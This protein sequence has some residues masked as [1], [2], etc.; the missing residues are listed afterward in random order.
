[1]KKSILTLAVLLLL[2]LAASCTAPV[3][4]EEAG[5]NHQFEKQVV[6]PSCTDGY[7]IYTC[8]KCTYSYTDDYKDALGHQFKESIAD[9]SCV[10]KKARVFT[11]QVCKYSYNEETE[12][13]GTLHQYEAQVKKPTM[14]EGGY[15]EYTCK[16]CDDRYKDS[17]T[18]PLH[19]STGLSYKKVSDGYLLIGV[20][21]CKDSEIVVPSVNEQG[22][23]VVGIEANAF[24]GSK[25]TKITVLD[26]IWR[27]EANAFA[28]CSTLKELVIGES[29]ELADGAFGG[30]GQLERLTVCLG[31]SCPDFDFANLKYLGVVGQMSPFT[32]ERLRKHS[33]LEEVEVFEG[34]TRIPEGAFYECANLKKLSLPTSLKEIGNNAFSKTGLTSLYIPGSVETTEGF[35]SC[36]QLKEVVMGEGLKSSLSFSGCTTLEKVSLPSTLQTVSPNAFEGCTALTSLKLPAGLKSISYGAFK[37]CTALTDL[38]LPEGLTAIGYEAFYGCGGYEIT[39]LPAGV[40]E[41][42]KDAFFGVTFKR[43]VAPVS[44]EKIEGA[45][46]NNTTLTYADLSPAAGLKEVGKETFYGCTSLQEATLPEDLI[47]VGNHAF[48]ECD[49][50]TAVKTGKKLQNINDWAF[51]GC[52]KLTAPTLYEGLLRIENSAFKGCEGVRYESL[53]KTLILIDAFAFEGSYVETLYYTK[54][55]QDAGLGAML[56]NSNVKHLVVEEGV[57]RIYSSF[58]RN[59][60][61]ESV[62]FPS[63]LQTIESAAFNDCASLKKITLPEGLLQIDSV[64][65]AGSG[66]TSLTL[67]RSVK[68]VGQGAFEDCIALETLT[69]SSADVEIGMRAFDSTAVKQLTV[70]QGT[71]VIGSEA[72]YGMADLEK[73]SLPASLKTVGEGAF[74]GCKRLSDVSFNGASVALESKAFSG[75]NALKSLKKVT[76]TACLYDSIGGTGL[77]T[78]KDGMSYAFG[79]LFKAEDSG[80]K[81][82][83]VIPS[84]VTYICDSAFAGCGKPV[85]VMM[86]SGVSHVGKGVFA[87]CEDLEKVVFSKGLTLLDKNAFRGCVSLKEIVLTDALSEIEE[88]V[89]DPAVHKAF[90][91]IVY[92]ST[93]ASWKK[94]EGSG[95]DGMKLCTVSCTDGTVEGLYGWGAL[96]S[97]VR[98]ELDRT[99]TLHFY[100]SGEVKGFLHNGK[101]DRKLVSRIVFHEGV[102]AIGEDNGFFSM[103]QVKEILFPSTLTYAP[104]S[105]FAGTGFEE[106]FN[107]DPGALI[108]SGDRLL[109]V[110]H[111]AAGSFKMPAGVKAIGQFAFSGCTGI[112]GVDLSGINRIERGAFNGCTALKD[113]VFSDDPM[114]IENNAF[115]SCHGITELTIPANITISGAPFS[116]DG[117]TRLVIEGTVDGSLA[118][119]CDILEEVVLKGKDVKLTNVPLYYCTKLRFLV[120]EQRPLSMDLSYLASGAVVACMD[121]KTANEVKSAF[122]LVKVAVYSENVPT[123]Q[124]LF[125]HYN[126]QGRAELYS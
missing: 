32:A 3:P 51:A 50:L 30:I 87:G 76:V 53:P 19:F 56:S 88:G 112:T 95:S 2:L 18:D 117:L 35:T 120:L 67:P 106:D 108:V 119:H 94:I 81:A 79:F 86:H 45:F 73:L 115:D 71:T 80:L 125:W 118:V 83:T 42:G 22:G 84:D 69:L 105:A 74:C 20:G 116:C 47:T 101:V 6:E 52:E 100:G 31:E 16:L 72:F 58:A 15:T 77:I 29:V 70:P 85:T 40:K 64:A 8:T 63:T 107:Q 82:N 91:R 34:V 25:V 62:S 90:E 5:C 24:K 28:G 27:V 12:Q 93:L 44:L 38:V 121:A 60:P 17:F 46:K 124:G 122:P 26:G 59:A 126:G 23:Q 54:A 103:S 37:N 55:M 114:V 21:S 48:Y 113:L 98:Y 1:M 123:D 9:A 102:T 39:L 41:I 4:G 68:R 7:T 111:A 66:I 49:E 104:I 14:N 65:F 99:G 10:E 109:A 61:I 11:C 89:F 78:V 13:Q 36:L 43:F 92:Q 75:C 96:S 97:A 33:A 110:S 57:T